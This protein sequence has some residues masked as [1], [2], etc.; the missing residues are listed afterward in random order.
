MPTN[1]DPILRKIEL[2]MAP[3]PGWSQASV[4]WLKSTCDFFYKSFPWFALPPQHVSHSSCH[5]TQA[6]LK[7]TN[8]RNRHKLNWSV[9]L[10][11]VPL[12][13]STAFRHHPFH[14]PRPSQPWSPPRLR[15]PPGP[16]DDVRGEGEPAKQ[17][18]E[19]SQLRVSPT[20]SDGRILT[21]LPTGAGKARPDATVQHCVQDWSSWQQASS[22]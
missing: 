6:R 17:Q 19:Q 11:H 21:R 16:D 10:H 22:D 9:S 3:T 20:S 1:N 7:L 2:D 15:P 5:I 13:E 8:F 14:P 18:S 12:L 4:I